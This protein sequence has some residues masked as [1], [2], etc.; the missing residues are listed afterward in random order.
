M[1]LVIKEKPSKSTQYCMNIIV[2]IILLIQVSRKC[3]SF[4]VVL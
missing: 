3:S 4:P 1:E 2:M